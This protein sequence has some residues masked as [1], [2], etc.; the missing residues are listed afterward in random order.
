M[1]R[2]FLPGG[3]SSIDSFDY[4]PALARH[5]GQETQGANA[6]TPF[7]GQRGAVMQ[8]PWTFRPKGQSGMDVSDLLPHL[9]ELVDDCTF[10]HSMVK[11]SNAHGPAIFPMS[12]GFI[13]QG[14][15]SIGAWISYGL[16]SE[17]KNLPSFVVLPDRRG[18]P[19][20][21]FAN[22]GNGFLPASHPG[23]IL[24]DRK[25][26]IVDLRPA[27]WLKK[28]SAASSVTMAAT[29]ANPA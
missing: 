26:P 25:Q 4:K 15:P 2:I 16:G 10:L 13:F 21:G 27:A 20:C 24:A 19:P 3:F 9:G 7:F 1:I 8:F 14:F 18:L 22:W 6:I 12:T 29:S 28:A 5:H 17:N 23:V 11:R